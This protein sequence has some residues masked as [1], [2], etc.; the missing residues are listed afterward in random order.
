MRLIQVQGTVF[1]G[2]FAQITAALRRAVTPSPRPADT[3]PWLVHIILDMSNITC[4]DTAA[5][6]ALEKTWQELR[7]LR[8]AHLVL[9]LPP[10]LK[11]NSEADPTLTGLHHSVHVASK[12]SLDV[13]AKATEATAESPQLHIEWDLDTAVA[14]CEDR[15]ITRCRL[16]EGGASAPSPGVKPSLSL[17]FILQTVAPSYAA[18]A[19]EETDGLRVPRELL[20]WFHPIDVGARTVLWREGEKSSRALVLVSGRLKASD[21]NGAVQICDVSGCM[22]GE[23]GLITG[24]RRQNT[25][26][27]LTPARLFELTSESYESMIAKAPRVAFVL[28]SAA[29]KYAGKRLHN[30]A[31][32]LSQAQATP[33]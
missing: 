26:E 4:L 10:S 1:F 5:A 18:E 15:L 6:K 13:E 11:A 24:E 27:T 17:D 33:V 7:E 21:E 19:A 23:F 9:V 25:V 20:E 29:L 30:L 2:N 16:D 32:V 22:L 12:E 14:W 28:A 3:S 8:V 31:I